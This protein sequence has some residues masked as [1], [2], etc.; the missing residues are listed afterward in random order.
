M[1]TFLPAVTCCWLFAQRNIFF[2]DIECLFV[3]GIENIILG[4]FIENFL[5]GNFIEL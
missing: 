2:G 3:D 1:E 5:P 4:L